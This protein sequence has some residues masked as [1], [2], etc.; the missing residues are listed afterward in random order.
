MCDRCVI[1]IDPSLTG[2]ALVALY[3]NGQSKELEFGSP[4]AKSLHARIDRYKK[5]ADKAEAFIKEHIPELCLIEG[6][7]FAAKGKSVIT[8]GE[9]G[10]VIR[11]RIVGLADSTVEIA[12]TM[13]K[14]FLTGRGN[15]SKMDVVQKLARKLD[16][17]FPSDNIADGFGLAL[18]GAAVLEF[19]GHRLLTQYEKDAVSLA[20]RQIQQEQ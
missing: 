7:A 4:P 20:S 6:Y 14:R 10:G 2:F 3:E 12:P 9:F 13:L 8:L 11:D 18:L 16:R 15:A 19:R 1:G 17:N 5:M